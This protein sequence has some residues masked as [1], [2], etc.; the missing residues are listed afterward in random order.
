MKKII[1]AFTFVLFAAASMAQAVPASTAK[2]PDPAKVAARKEVTTDLKTLN[3]DEIALKAAKKSNDANALATAKSK[4]QADRV[5]LKAAVKSA[6][7]LGVKPPKPM[8]K[9][10]AKR[11]QAAAARKKAGK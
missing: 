2:T 9:Q 4:V 7:A 8:V 1:F 10:M 3:Q 5:A 11:R 6:K